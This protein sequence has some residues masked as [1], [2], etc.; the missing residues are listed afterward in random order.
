MRK[1]YSLEEC[2]KEEKVSF[3][4]QIIK[5][6]QL[7]WSQITLAPK[8]GLGTEQVPQH[9]ICGDSIPE[10]IIKPDT[11]LLAL[12]FAGKKPMVGFRDKETF[13]ILWFDRNFTLY[14]HG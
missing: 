7:T 8:H 11:N 4:D 14:K 1:K 5:L 3:V 12:R 13:Y 9:C 6:S 2:N 10:N